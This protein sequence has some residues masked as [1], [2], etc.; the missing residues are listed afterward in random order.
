GSVTVV[1]DVPDFLRAPPMLVN[2]PLGFGHSSI[3]FDGTTVTPL[4]QA[5]P[6]NGR[7]TS[8]V[9]FVVSN[10]SAEAL[11]IVK[12]SDTAGNN[13]ASDLEAQFQA[14]INSALAELGGG[15]TITVGLANGAF[16]LKGSSGVSF[17]GNTIQVSFEKPDFLDEFQ[18]L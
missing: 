13:S 5:V 16:T 15:K 1:L 6:T 14:A 11:G 17:R 2:D 7:L 4:G 8:D 10:G 18:H 12:A 3:A 9:S